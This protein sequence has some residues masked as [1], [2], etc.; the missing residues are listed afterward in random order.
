MECL[1]KGDLLADFHFD[2]L[3]PGTCATPEND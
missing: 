1:G 2:T 3:K